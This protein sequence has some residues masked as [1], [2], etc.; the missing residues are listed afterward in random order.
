M[1]MGYG[2]DYPSA[3][4]ITDHTQAFTGRFGKV[5]ALKNSTVDLVAENITENTSTTISGI[6]LHHSAEICGVITSVQ[7]ASGDAVIAYRL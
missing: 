6:P 2:Y 1:K 3:I 5:V 7:V 4:I